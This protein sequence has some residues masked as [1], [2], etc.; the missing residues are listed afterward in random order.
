MK[1]YDKIKNLAE[2][3]VAKNRNGQIG[4][5][6]LYFDPEHVL[7]SNAANSAQAES[8]LAEYRKSASRAPSATPQ[9]AQVEA[10]AEPE[11]MEQ[12]IDDELAKVFS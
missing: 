7:F 3:I 1:K 12:D 2:V 8:A 10:I 11:N 4:T 5:V 6:H 9:Q